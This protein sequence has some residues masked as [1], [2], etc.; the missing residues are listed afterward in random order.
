MSEPAKI[1]DE[2][3][4]AL[5]Y[6]NYKGETA[7]RRIVPAS[8]RFGATEHHPEPQWV[9]EAFDLDKGAERTFA[10]A[11]FHGRPSAELTLSGWRLRTHLAE[12]RAQLFAIEAVK[13]RER[14]ALVACREPLQLER[15]VD[16]LNDNKH[17]GW[18][19][20]Y[21]SMEDPEPESW[22]VVGDEK[23]SNYFSQFEARAIA[24]AYMD[25]DEAEPRR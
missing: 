5:R 9:V 22:I 17:S 23:I 18:D 2:R 20:W 14:L 15:A 10:L 13:L 16:I 4:V 8:I 19:D 25:G 7:V 6:T 11:D 1:P 21:I 3:A 12:D 24:N